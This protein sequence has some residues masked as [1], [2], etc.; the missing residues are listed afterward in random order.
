MIRWLSQFIC[1][2]SGRVFFA[3]AL[4]LSLSSIVWAA[5][6]G[7]VCFKET[8]FHPEIAR[9]STEKQRGLMKRRALASNEGM[10]FVY[11][12]E[13]QPRFW[14]KNMLMPLDFVWLDGKKRVV[15]VSENIP[16][17]GKGDCPTLSISGSAQYILEVA[18]GTI[19]KFGIKMSDQAIIKI[20]EKK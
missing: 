11:D 19:K 2:R 7:S 17:C 15:G 4:L 18:A 16:A 14:M 13:G 10:L 12:R 6:M 9:T 5:G 1:N 20:Q 3:S 8:C